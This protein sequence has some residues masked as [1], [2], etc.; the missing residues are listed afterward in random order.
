[1]PSITPA[2]PIRQRGS[3]ALRAGRAL[4]CARRETITRFGSLATAIAG[5]HP[6]NPAEVAP[7]NPAARSST[8]F[9]SSRPAW[10][11]G[12]ARPSPKRRSRARSPG[13]R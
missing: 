1:M 9:T 5:Q 7:C 11:R 6:A 2:A 10:R 4:C 12:S 8:A 13:P 3:E